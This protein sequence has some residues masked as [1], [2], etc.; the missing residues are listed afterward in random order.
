MLSLVFE[1]NVKGWIP[2]NNGLK[3]SLNQKFPLLHLCNQRIILPPVNHE[4]ISFMLF[5]LRVANRFSLTGV[6]LKKIM[7]IS[8]GQ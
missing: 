4:L 1:D 5:F 7:Q 8:I 6:K 2:K 3:N